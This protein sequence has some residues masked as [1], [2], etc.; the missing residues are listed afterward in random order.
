MLPEKHP[1]PAAPR[2]IINKQCQTRTHISSFRDLFPSSWQ[3]VLLWSQGYFSSQVWWW[4]SRKVQ[5]SQMSHA[6][7]WRLLT[8]ISEVSHPQNYTELTD[9]HLLTHFSKWQL[10][11]QEERTKEILDFQVRRMLRDHLTQQTYFTARRRSWW[12]Q[13][14]SHWSKSEN[15]LQ[16]PSKSLC[17]GLL[18]F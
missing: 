5:A 10:M 18:G 2:H 3:K 6:A 8:P 13:C 17:R 14:E 15:F 7:F 1:S 4:H 9:T 11:S 16:I 12:P